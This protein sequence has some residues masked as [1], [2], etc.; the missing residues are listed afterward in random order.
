MRIVNLQG[1]IQQVD[2]VV[3]Q[4]YSL[5]KGEAEDSLVDTSFYEQLHPPDA[6]KVYIGQIVGEEYAKH[7]KTYG[8]C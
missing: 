7:L 4:L 5:E 1:H 3:S 8:G 6:D 2:Q